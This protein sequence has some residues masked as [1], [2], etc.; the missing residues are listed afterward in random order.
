MQFP[1]RETVARIRAE[2]PTG[3]RVELVKMDD[4]FAPPVGTIGTVVAVDDA[5]DLCMLWSTGSTLKVILGE[6][7][8]R[9][10]DETED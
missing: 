1:D 3:T 2:Y 8:V 7:I 9:K 5:G 10:I 6:D 4:V